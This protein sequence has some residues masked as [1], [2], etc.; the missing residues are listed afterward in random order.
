MAKRKLN[1][2]KSVNTKPLRDGFCNVPVNCP[3]AF[4]DEL[5]KIKSKSESRNLFILRN[6]IQGVKAFDPVKAEHL[7]RILNENEV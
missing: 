3:E 5:D 1:L 7:E 2:Y 6:I 4:R